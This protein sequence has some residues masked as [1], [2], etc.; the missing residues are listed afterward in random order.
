[1]CSYSVSRSSSVLM[2]DDNTARCV[3]ELYDEAA[4]QLDA[5]GIEYEA[6]DVVQ[7]CLLQLEA[8]NDQRSD[9]WSDAL[10]EFFCLRN[11]QLAEELDNLF[12]FV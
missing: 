5:T 1:M 9:D 7:L 10:E 11:E 4:E 8:Y 6:D 12:R 3:Q 2:E